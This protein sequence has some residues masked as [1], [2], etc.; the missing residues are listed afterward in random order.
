VGKRN[1]AA[2]LAGSKTKIEAI[3]LHA[4]LFGAM[5]PDYLPDCPDCDTDRHVAP[6]PLHDTG[7]FL[8]RKC[9]GLIVV[10]LID[11]E[12]VGVFVEE[13]ETKAPVD[14]A[15]VGSHEYKPHELVEEPDA[16]HVG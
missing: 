6:E 9:Q 1:K 8:C 2:K 10:V 14:E 7:V 11:G 15:I 5:L 3:W 13:L 12:E 4:E 16:F